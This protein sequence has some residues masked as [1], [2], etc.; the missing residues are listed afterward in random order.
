MENKQGDQPAFRGPRF[1]PWNI[2]LWFT[3]IEA[4]FQ[5]ASITTDADKYS[6][7]V[8]SMDE[9]NIREVEDVLENPPE[10][11][12]Y[13]NLKNTLIER[14]CKSQEQKTR[15]LLNREEIGDRTPS[16]YLRHLRELAGTTVP[17]DFIKTLWMERLPPN[18]RA[19]LIAQE[20]IGLDQAA[21]IADAI[22]AQETQP[23][24]ALEETSSAANRSMMLEMS[25]L[26]DNLT[27]RLDA[28]E[29]AYKPELAM[30]RT[31]PEQRNF[32]RRSRSRSRPRSAVR[33]SPGD[34][35]WYH[36]TFGANAYQCRSPCSFQEGNDDGR[37]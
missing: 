3:M 5:T 23:Q 10:M 9:K 18:V 1:L 21:K 7:V 26:F 15:Q 16:K 20:P 6:Y 35:C 25:K 32:R 24:R 37:Q 36:H 28:M 30:M 29:A 14:A 12:K 33:Y 8:S 4:C 19:I 11:G 22:V 17:E 13:E 31:R 34:V 27:T 2:K